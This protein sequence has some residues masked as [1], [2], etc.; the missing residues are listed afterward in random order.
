VALNIFSVIIAAY[1]HA[2]KNVYTRKSTCIRQKATAV[3]RDVGLLCRMWVR[4]LEL[5]PSF[6]ETW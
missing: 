3:Y 6:L 5:A 4:N 2:H 1:F